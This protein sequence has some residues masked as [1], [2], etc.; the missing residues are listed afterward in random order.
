MGTHIINPCPLSAFAPSVLPGSSLSP[1]APQGN[2][3]KG[4]SLTPPKL[5]KVIE[6]SD[7]KFTGV[8]D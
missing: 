3:E 7:S 4:A 6:W 2:E 5:K 1:M 8:S